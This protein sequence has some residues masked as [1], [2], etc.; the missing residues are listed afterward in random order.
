[1][2]TAVTVEA[3]VV[4]LASDVSGMPEDAIRSSGYLCDVMEHEVY[5]LIVAAIEAHYK[6]RFDMGIYE[7]D[8]IKELVALTEDHLDAFSK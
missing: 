1:L 4:A 2:S 6:F 5:M 7:I 3:K 8:S